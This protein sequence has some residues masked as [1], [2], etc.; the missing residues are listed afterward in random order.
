MRFLTQLLRKPFRRLLMA[1]ELRDRVATADQLRLIV[2]AGGTD[3]E[4]WIPTEQC[5]VDLLQ[6]ET[7]ATYFQPS[8]VQGILAEHVWEHLTEEEGRIAARTCFQF[9]EPGGYLRV[10]VPDGNHP[11]PDYIDKV[12][13]G[14]TGIGA[15]DHKVLY[16]HQTFS[17]IFRAAGFDVRLIEYFD[18]EGQFHCA[19]WDVSRGLVR[20]SLLFDQRNVEKRYAYT[21]L[22]LDAIKPANQ[23]AAKA[24]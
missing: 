9:L 7:W 14:G 3:M 11:S 20:R 2:G 5:L 18:T 8:T 16:N 17:E 21:S 24:A 13:P 22:F 12:R 23:P 15:D 4:G 19:A 10:A 1:R 6:P